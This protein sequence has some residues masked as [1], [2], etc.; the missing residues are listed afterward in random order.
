MVPDPVVTQ[1]LYGRFA[2]YFRQHLGKPKGRE[3]ER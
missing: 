3:K 2:L 1:R